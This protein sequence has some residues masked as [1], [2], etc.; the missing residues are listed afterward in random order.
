MVCRGR[1]SLVAQCNQ[2]ATSTRHRATGVVGD[3]GDVEEVLPVVRQSLADARRDVREHEREGD[4]STAPPD[5]QRA[6]YTRH[7]TYSN[8]TWRKVPSNMS[9]S[10]NQH[11]ASIMPRN[12]QHAPARVMQ[13]ATSTGVGSTV[14]A[15]GAELSVA[16]GRTGLPC[17]RAVQVTY[18]KGWKKFNLQGTKYSIPLPKSGRQGRDA[19]LVLREDEVCPTRPIAAVVGSSA[20]ESARC[21]CCSLCE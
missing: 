7:A 20:H 8:G 21:V 16:V 17:L 9:R 5:I 18:T 2:R 13:H 1:A 19:N 12:M 4:R 15:I 11:S 6:T 10:Y 14:N 3:S